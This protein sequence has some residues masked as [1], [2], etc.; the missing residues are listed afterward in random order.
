MG[1]LRGLDEGVG[2]ALGVTRG[3]P[4]GVWTTRFKGYPRRRVDSIRDFRKACGGEHGGGDCF[5]ISPA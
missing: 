5:T 3:V 1:V 4:Y 2:E